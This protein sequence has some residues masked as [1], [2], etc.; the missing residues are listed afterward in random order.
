MKTLKNCL[1]LA[2][3]FSAVSVNAQTDKATT[4]R[5]VAAQHYVFI[6]TTANPLNASDINKIMS[7]MPGYTGG[8]N[9]NLNNLNYDLTVTPDSLVSYLPYYGRSYAPRIG[10]LPDDTGIKFKS[11]KFVYKS[12]PRKKGGWNISMI[13]KDTKDSYSMNLLITDTGYATLTVNSN[14]QQ[15]ISFDGYL[16]EPVKPKK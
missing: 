7:R 14:N 2:L 13:P 12:V 10:G 6:A 11:K 3:L 4:A 5:I 1:W 16:S 8:G 15:S 9:I